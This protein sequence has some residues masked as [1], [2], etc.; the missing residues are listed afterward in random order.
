MEIKLVFFSPTMKKKKRPACRERR[1]YVANCLLVSFHA[2]RQLSVSCTKKQGS[3][4]AA[5][6]LLLLL[7]F[8]RE[9]EC[10]AILSRG[11]VPSHSLGR[12][13]AE[14][15]SR[16][17]EKKIQR[18]GTLRAARVPACPGQGGKAPW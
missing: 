8:S 3:A 6:L 14:P 11:R 10:R 16:E 2:W 13:S 17:G 4:A 1:A 5:A 15:F 9:G 12:A 7:P 18:V